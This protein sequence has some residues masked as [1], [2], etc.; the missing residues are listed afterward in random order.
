[1]TDWRE[2][3]VFFPIGRSVSKL[4][5]RETYGISIPEAN[6]HSSWCDN[7]HWEEGGVGLGRAARVEDNLRLAWCEAFVWHTGNR[8]P[9]GDFV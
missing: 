2:P 7:K 3:C 6:Q 4:Q 8:H 9:L 1:M 5:N